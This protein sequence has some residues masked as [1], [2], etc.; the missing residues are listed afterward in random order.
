MPSLSLNL[1]L[2]AL[3][4]LFVNGVRAQDEPYFSVSCVDNYSDG[5]K[6]TAT[7]GDQYDILCGVDYWGGDIATANGITFEQCI[8]GWK[9][10][11]PSHLT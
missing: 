3:A 7:N 2:S 5:K 1:G 6:Y 10:S 11:L 9:S 4:L 8:E